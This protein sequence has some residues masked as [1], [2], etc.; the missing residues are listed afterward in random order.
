MREQ[1]NRGQCFTDYVRI[2]LKSTTTSNYYYYYCYKIIENIKNVVV[3]NSV[4]ENEW[5]HNRG[6][7]QVMRCDTMCIVLGNGGRIRTLSWHQFCQARYTQIE[8]LY[9]LQH[10]TKQSSKHQHKIVPSVRYGSR[11]HERAN[12]WATRLLSRNKAPFCMNKS[13]QHSSGSLLYGACANHRLQTTN[14]LLDTVCLRLVPFISFYVIF[15]FIT[16]L[17]DP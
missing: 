15:F 2:K 14:C 6:N 13:I 8:D 12:Y 10:N 1:I 17:L 9:W 11:Q 16:V 4:C 7:V 5:S 3:F